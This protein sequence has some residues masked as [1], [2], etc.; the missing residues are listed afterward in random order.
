MNENEEI[1]KIQFTGKS[2]YIISLPK[3]WINDLGLRKGDQIIIKKQHDTT[4]QLIP[5]KNSTYNIQDDD[6]ILEI[7]NNDNKSIIRK[8]ISLYFIGFK[9]INIKPKFGRMKPAQRNLIKEAV[10]RMLIGTEIISDSTND[11]VIQVLVDSLGLSIDN[12]FKRMVHLAKSML[13]DVLLAIKEA[14]LDLANEV[15]KTDDEVDRFSFYIIRQL[16][17]AIQSESMLI[18]MGFFNSRNC[19]GYRVIAKN[20]ERTGDH[21]V[22]IAKELI[23]FKKPIQKSIYHKIREMTEFALYL[24]D[25]SCLSLFKKD[26]NHADITMD[27]TLKITEYEKNVLNETSS[28]TN[29]EEI[30]FIRKIIE[31]IKR[32]AEYAGDIAEIVLNINI[33]NVL[34]TNNK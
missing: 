21:A 16:K 22:L 11:I 25:Q 18:N 30:Y 7:N 10:K 3:N 20:I 13:M 23:H 27:N 5:P 6:A 33:E 2:S 31:N 24:I 12:A 1:R 4:L 34:K 9:T 8:I 32:V 29:N 14:N 28:I 15:I 19:L 17:I 26:F